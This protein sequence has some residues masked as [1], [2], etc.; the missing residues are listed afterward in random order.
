MDSI[1][2]GIEDAASPDDRRAVAAAIAAFHAETVAYEASRFTVAA[3][4]AAG[5]RAGVV[6]ALVYWDWLFVEAM[7][8]AAAY[9]GAGLGSALLARAEQHAAALDCHSAWLDTFQAVD[10][11]RR[12]GYEAFG[13]LDDY[14]AGQTRW[15]LRK[16]LVAR[17]PGTPLGVPPQR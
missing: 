6:F 8:V 14:P 3:R 11:Y 10:F 9:R 1:S 17:P 12:A 4:T 5:E 7:Y 13:H 2:I 15:F 16:A